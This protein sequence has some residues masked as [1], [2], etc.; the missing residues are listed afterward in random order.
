MKVLQQRSHEAVVPGAAL[1][2]IPVEAQNSA[3]G[4]R[5]TARDVPAATLQ[6]ERRTVGVG[7]PEG[8]PAGRN[9]K[10]GLD[11]AVFNEIE[12][13]SLITRVEELLSF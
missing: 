10:L 3:V 7:L 1:E 13:A 9:H 11:A 4:A 6:D 12:A 8:S 2:G 5:H